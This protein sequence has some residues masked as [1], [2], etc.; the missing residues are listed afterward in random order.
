MSETLRS[1][2]LAALIFCFALVGGVFVVLQN[3]MF[4]KIRKNRS[5]FSPLTAFAAFQTVEVYVLIGL[6]FVEVVI[7]FAVKYFK[8]L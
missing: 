8:G 1:V 4:R 3:R 5:V 6:V 7:V 2:V